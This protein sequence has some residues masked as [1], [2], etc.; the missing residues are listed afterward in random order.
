MTLN[1]DQTLFGPLTQ[2][3]IIIIQLKFI[4]NSQY[5]LGIFNWFYHFCNVSQ[6]T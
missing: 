6:V 2:S 1:P 3:I 5:V 4:S